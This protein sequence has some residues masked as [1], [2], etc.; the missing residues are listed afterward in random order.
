[1]STLDDLVDDL[2]ATL[3]APCILEDPD[4]RLL[5]FS[6]QR[7]VDQVRQRSILEKGSTPEVRTWFRSHG[8]GEAER[9]LRT[10]ADAELGIVS[11]ICVPV[12][13]L[14]RLQG[15]FW[16]LDAHGE[17]AESRWEEARPY[18]ESA[19]ALLSLAERRQARRD[20]SYR[21]VVEGGPDA[22]RSAAS[23]LA[24]A[25]GLAPDEPVRVA[26]VQRPD[27]AR[28]LPSRP[29]RGGMVWI[30]ESAEVCAAV[31]RAEPLTNASVDVPSVLAGL[32]LSRRVPDLDLRTIVG[33]GPVVPAIDDL[34]DARSGALVALR[35]GRQTGTSLT[36]WERLGPLRLLGV[37]RDADLAR[38]LVPADVATFL[39]GAQPALVE[40]VRTYLQEAASATRTASHLGVHRQTVYHRLEQ[41]ER[42]TGIDLSSGTGRLELQLALELA[43]FVLPRGPE[44]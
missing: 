28:Q 24:G 15:F 16:L 14:G 34:A 32:G 30:R 10:P 42:A 39:H 7:D 31:V 20:A 9:P 8:I 38:S 44:R 2:A 40:T 37:A 23:E 36:T 19:G 21:D 3:G 41:V 13:H 25:A 43:P 18:A 27:L 6:D 33:I 5:G 29:S 26:L 12:R 35:V 17:I 4:F 22:S 11:R 1:M